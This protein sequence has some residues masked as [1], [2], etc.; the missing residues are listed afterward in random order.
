MSRRLVLLGASNLLRGL[1]TVLR[2]ARA[3]WGDPLQA[4]AALGFGRSYGMRSAVLGRT[5]P[6]IADCGLWPALE[7]GPR[8]PTRAVLTDVGNDILYGAAPEQILGWVEA[9]L[10]R[11]RAAGAETVV[12]GLPLPRLELLSRPGYAALRTI[13]YPLHRWLPLAEARARARTLS[14]GLEALAAAGGATFVPAPL[15]WYGLDPIHVRPGRWREAFRAILFAPDAAAAGPAAEPEGTPSL[16]RVVL[17][18]PQRQWL[19]GRELHH[20]QPALRLPGGSS[21]SLF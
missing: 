3:A 21:L 17:A 15:H 11:L 19:F 6:A 8:L 18:R 2:A 13:V 1:P 5:L 9:C 16:P 12:A 10:A 20:A 14:A 7:S 4:L